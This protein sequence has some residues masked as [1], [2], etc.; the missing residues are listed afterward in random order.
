[1]LIGFTRHNATM[2]T[3]MIDDRAMS[4]R[5]AIKIIA[6]RN[7]APTLSITNDMPESGGGVTDGPDVAAS[8][9]D[10]GGDDDGEPARRRLHS[11]KFPPSFPP[12]LLGFEPLSHYVS[13]GRS[14]IYQLIA[15]GAF[16]QPIKVGKSSR[17]VKAEID[18]WIV[19]QSQRAGA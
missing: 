17:W 5:L 18:A 6:R 2:Y 15:A 4:Y 11:K 3:E 7:H 8:D 19:S 9:D 10:D 16:P 1:M 12:A 14:R 13:F